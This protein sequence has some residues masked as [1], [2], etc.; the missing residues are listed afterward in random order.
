MRVKNRKLPK[1]LRDGFKN[2]PLRE[3]V[4]VLVEARKVLREQRERKSV[5][6]ELTGDEK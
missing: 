6:I 4:K 1:K 2:L 3:R 5:K